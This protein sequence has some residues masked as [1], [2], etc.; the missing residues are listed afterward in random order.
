[1]S[2][3]E[4]NVSASEF[5]RSEICTAADQLNVNLND[6]LEFYLVQLMTDFMMSANLQDAGTS[7][8]RLETPL[9]LILQKAHE[10]PE[11][12]KVKILKG[13]GDTSL[14]FSGFF[15]DYFNRKLFS[16]DY[17]ITMGRTAY[18]NVSHILEDQFGDAE[19]SKMYRTLSER[20]QD[21]VDVLGAVSEQSSELQNSNTKIL[22]LFD[23]WNQTGSE[24]IR[25]K[26][27]EQGFDPVRVT[28][29]AQ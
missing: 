5:F 3:L 10:A 13:M 15:Q 14:Y 2:N 24:R 16:V 6:E 7:I 11:D 22:E 12:Q 17:Y 8:H 27:A 4:L 9:A 28:R 20:F 23:R 25:Q 26:L 29:K 21:F 18:D 19:F 1:M